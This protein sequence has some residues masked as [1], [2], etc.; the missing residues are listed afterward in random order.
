MDKQIGVWLAVI[1]KAKAD[2]TGTLNYNGLIIDDLEA[3]IQDMKRAQEETERSLYPCEEC[4]EKI[5]TTMV[6]CK[7]CSRKKY[8]WDTEL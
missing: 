1:A 6:I 5:I 2:I 4:G 8:P 7:L 3:L